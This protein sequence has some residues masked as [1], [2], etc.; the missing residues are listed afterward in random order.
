MERINIVILGAGDIAIKRHIPAILKS[1]YINLHG[2]LN[3]HPESTKAAAERYRVNA[4][5]DLVLKLSDNTVRYFDFD[6]THPQEELELTDLHE[7]FAKSILEDTAVDVT[8]ED[9]VESV[10][11]I[12]A[13]E[14]ANE[15]KQ[16]QILR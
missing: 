1:D 9:G 6:Q 15:E 11:I 4:Y 7:R 10:Q 3:R 5:Q 14:K 13:F 2:I 12:E 8:E 16:Y